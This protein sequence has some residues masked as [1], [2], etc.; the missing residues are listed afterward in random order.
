MIG[1]KDVWFLIGISINCTA[2]TKIHNNSQKVHVFVT[3]TSRSHG[4]MVLIK[5]LN[6]SEGRGCFERER[7]QKEEEGEKAS[8]EILNQG[9]NEI[10]F[11]C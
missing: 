7:C 6:E 9:K 8:S 2:C 1:H 5:K 4:K 3:K 10:G 11:F